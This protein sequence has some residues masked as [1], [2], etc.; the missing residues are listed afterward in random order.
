M[1]DTYVT[2]TGHVVG[3]DRDGF[4]IAY[5]W[6]GRT[7]TDKASAIKNGFE[8]TGCDDF[9][10]GAVRDGRLVGYWWMD[11]PTRKDEETLARIGRECGLTPT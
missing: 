3:N 4:D 8:A 5:D 6:D 1:T 7:F 10:I 11:E 9:N 2:I